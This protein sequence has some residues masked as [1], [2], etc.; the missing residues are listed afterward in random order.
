[1]SGAIYYPYIHLRDVDWLKATLLSFPKLQRMVPRRY[2]PD[3][4][5]E[6]REFLSLRG[7]DRRPL[8]ERADMDGPT[9]VT[10]Q[11]RLMDW[12]RRDFEDPF[13]GRAFFRRFTRESAAR[14]R[15]GPDAFRLHRGKFSDRFL[16]ELRQLGLVWPSEADKES[17][18]RW[19]S[20]HPKL[21]EAIMSAF[22]ASI[23]ADEGLSVV[24]SSGQVHRALVGRDPE[25]AYRSMVL[26]QATA[27]MGGRTVAR[28]HLVQIVIMTGFDLTALTA[29]DMRR[30]L[31]QRKAF[32]DFRLEMAKLADETEWSMDERGRHA[33]LKRKAA[34]AI[35]QWKADM[36]RMRGFA[37]EFFGGNA[38]ADQSEGFF[39]DVVK[40]LVGDVV[41]G[42]AAAA[43]AQAVA[44][45]P[46]MAPVLVSAGAGLAVGVVSHALRSADR[47]RKRRRESPYRYLSI[48][49]RAARRKRKFPMLVIESPKMPYY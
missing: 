27:P 29:D 9:A 47:V 36:G 30:V 28:D 16:D 4:P 32:D 26:G 12:L 35:D 10:A 14:L 40:D 8:V 23:A 49:Q 38:L 22:A 17:R 33:T 1:M 24:T 2:E 20:I 3:D 11:G 44:A 5:P 34:G 37:K 19:F 31:E 42:G 7:P 18:D 43:A 25:A 21:G 48:V 15:G 41:K 46:S 39:K 45:A 6:I 13:R